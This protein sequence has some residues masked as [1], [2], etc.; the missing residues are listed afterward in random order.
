MTS[1]TLAR[2]E[3]MLGH[4]RRFSCDAPS[5]W[6]ADR[7]SREAARRPR[8]RSLQIMEG[9][10]ALGPL[11]G[12]V[13][14]PIEG[15]GNVVY[16]PRVDLPGHVSGTADIA[17]GSFDKMEEA[18]IVHDVFQVFLHHD[19]FVNFPELLQTYQRCV[20]RRAISADGAFVPITTEDVQRVLN[21]ALHLV[22]TANHESKGRHPYSSKH[23]QQSSGP[24]ET[25]RVM[26][27]KDL[28]PGAVSSPQSH[29]A[30]STDSPVALQ[31]IF[32]STSLR[33]SQDSTSINDSLLSRVYER[34]QMREGEGPTHAIG[35]RY[36][37][38]LL[39]DAGSYGES[40]HSR[41]RPSSP[42]RRSSDPYPY[43]PRSSSPQQRTRKSGVS[44]VDRLFESAELARAG[45]MPSSA[46][47]MPV[48]PREE[49]ISSLSHASHNSNRESARGRLSDTITA[50]TYTSYPRWGAFS[51]KSPAQGDEQR[52]VPLRSQTPTELRSVEVG[53]SGIQNIR[54]NQQVGKDQERRALSCEPIVRL[55]TD[56]PNISDGLKKF[57]YPPPPLFPDYMTT[58]K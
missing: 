38:P 36:S 50:S 13:K 4:G 23:D 14:R 32:P 35:N 5:T 39:Y 19:N 28:F 41:L 58:S 3:A 29:V 15:R 53:G 2:E 40:S 51:E 44:L 49:T 10:A 7:A 43:P 21:T 52:V 24:T 33:L 11:R 25:W 30:A 46:S 6:T 55:R 56:M 17:L 47:K 57:P 18:A 1:C 9:D 22:S 54:Q 12:V 42:L 48:V 20:P 8:A 16:E 26:Q 37:A 45:S 27:P 34:T 31:A